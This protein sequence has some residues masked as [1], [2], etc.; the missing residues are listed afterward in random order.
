MTFLKQ[1]IKD[2]IGYGRYPTNKEY[3]RLCKA[4]IKKYP[5]LADTDNPQGY[6]SINILTYP[7]YLH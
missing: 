1:N 6:V 3:K 5:T 2:K 7:S 4:L